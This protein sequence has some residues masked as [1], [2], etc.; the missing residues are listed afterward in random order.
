LSYDNEQGIVHV[1]F[2]N[3]ASGEEGSIN[4][5]LAIAADGVHSTVRKLLLVPT[6]VDYAG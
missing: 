1:R 5:E 6:R 3:V 4:V 2:V